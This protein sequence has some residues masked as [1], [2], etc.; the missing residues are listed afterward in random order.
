[1]FG[2]A[3]SSDHA[4]DLERLTQ[5]VKALEERCQ[6]LA[7]KLEAHAAQSEKLRL[8]QVVLGM[9]FDEAQAQAQKAVAGLVDRFEALRARI[10]KASPTRPPT[11]EV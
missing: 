4:E 3:P 8:D 10:R 6:A 1:M 5:Q 2:R 11:T 7:E 9:R